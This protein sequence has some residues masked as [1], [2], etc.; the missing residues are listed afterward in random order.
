MELYLKII[1]V[2]AAVF[3]V[4][5]VILITRQQCE[6]KEK[7]TYTKEVDY[8]LSYGLKNKLCQEQS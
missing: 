1:S 3:D 5:M 6:K 8:L 4:V 7:P 2:V